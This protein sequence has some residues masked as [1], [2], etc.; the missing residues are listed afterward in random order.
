MAENYLAELKLKTKAGLEPGTELAYQ[1]LK[2][3]YE[4]A[5]GELPENQSHMKIGP[6]IASLLFS[7]S[8]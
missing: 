6:N 2:Q 5:L 8:N 7:S 1:E 4:K 3:N